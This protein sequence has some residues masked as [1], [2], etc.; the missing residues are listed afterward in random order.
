MQIWNP[1]HGCKKLSPGCKNCYVY[2]RDEEVGRDASLVSQTKDFNLP[3]KKGRNH[4]FKLKPEDGT[5]YTCMTSDFFLNEADAW[6]DECW[7]MISLRKDLNFYIITKRID[8]FSDCIPLDW[9]DGYDNVTICCTCENQE[10]ADYRLPIFLSLPIKNKEIICEP[11]LEEINLEKYLA[12]EIKCVIAGGESGNTARECNFDW[13]LNLRKQCES[14]NVSFYFK[15]T[16][17]KFIKD[18][19]LYEIDRKFQLSQANKANV[20]YKYNN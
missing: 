14:K 4:T 9:K 18:G 15:Q 8:R 12:P 6:R 20:N 1:W 17:A 19:K 10:M 3:L 16:G 11:I 13:I 7:Q 5:V 2:R